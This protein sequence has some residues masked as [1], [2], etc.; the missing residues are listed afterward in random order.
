MNKR[1][2]HP[3]PSVETGFAYQTGFGNEFASETLP[4][5][6]S[7]GQN[8]PQR[9]PRGFYAELSRARPSPRFGKSPARG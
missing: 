2:S 4:G 6:L 1:L 3:Q 9:T 5:A 7:V 8:S